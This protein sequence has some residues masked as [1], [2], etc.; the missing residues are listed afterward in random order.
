MSKSVTLVNTT[1]ACVSSIT[2][3]YDPV[4]VQ[5][6]ESVQYVVKDSNGNIYKTGSLAVSLSAGAKTAL[7][8]HIDSVILP[9]IDTAEGL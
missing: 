1:R 7:L 5:P 9:A 4:A 8:S 2:I 3:Q 6:I